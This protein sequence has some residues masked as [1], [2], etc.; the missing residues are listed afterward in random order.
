MRL[1]L[2]LSLFAAPLAAGCPSARLC[3][4]AECTANASCV[5]LTEG[6]TCRCVTGYVER[7]GRCQPEGSC[8]KLATVLCQATGNDEQVCAALH[9]GVATADGGACER[10]LAESD[11]A[12]AVNW[13]GE[14]EP[15][16]AREL[17]AAYRAFLTR[18][19]LDPCGAA[20]ELLCT[21]LRP[22][23]R[24]CGAEAA[25]ETRDEPSCRAVLR[26]YDSAL[27]AGA[28]P[29]AEGGDAGAEPLGSDVLVHL[30]PDPSNEG[31]LPPATFRSRLSAKR[32]EI[33]ACYDGALASFPGLRGRAVYLVRID[34]SGL[35][36][37]SLGR[38]EGP[39]VGSGVAQCVLDVILLLDF[40]D[41]PPTGGS[42]AVHVAL[43]F[44]Q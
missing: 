13:I 6:E 28:L 10:S 18:S 44:G 31:T 43:D 9:E 30:I 11:A 22:G 36:T 35:V 40:S 42:F 5:Q 8:G 34:A 39:I 19:L 14:V 25:V 29:A 20:T 21:V 37:A 4:G 12:D 1:A 15:M 32:E 24:G 26:G 41:E 27:L 33:E 23:E 7:S 16:L 17:P 2:L 3:G 38:G